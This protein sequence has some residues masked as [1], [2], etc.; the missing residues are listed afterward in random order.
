MLLKEVFN[1][2]PKLFP[3]K[4]AIIDRNRRFIYREL[5]E[6]WNR[7]A[8]ALIDLGLKKGECVGYILKNCAEIIDVYAAAAKI[9]VVVVGVNYRLSPEGMKTVLEDMKC[10]VLL[11]DEYV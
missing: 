1:R 2:G 5:G 7:L 3:N 6:R 8:N 10:P 9:G 4:V 11:V